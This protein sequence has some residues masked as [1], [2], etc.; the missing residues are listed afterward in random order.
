M[1]AILV[2]LSLGLVASGSFNVVLWQRL[3]KQRAETE[4]LQ[5][6]AA[7]AEALRA[8]V[9]G[10]KR[11]TAAQL[12]S[13]EEGKREVARLRNETAQ[14]RKQLKEAEAQ[15]ARL[16][17][18]AAAARARPEAAGHSDQNLPSDLSPEEMRV[19]E[20]AKL[21]PEQLAVLR[22]DAN[23]TRCIS[24][25]KQIGLALRMWANDHKD[26]FPPDLLSVTNE[27]GSPKILVCPSSPNPIQVTNWNQVTAATISYQFLNPNGNE[28]DPQ[29]PLTTCPIHGHMG[30]SDGSVHRK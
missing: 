30:L 17:A 22:A 3:A 25:M 6:S 27:L 29:K 21:S 4:A 11:S 14:L 12:A 5:A 15:R 20:L 28:Q 2:F 23:S 7:E 24:N 10:I 26:V 13:A 19:A 8:E 16:V 1:K 9:E 18:E